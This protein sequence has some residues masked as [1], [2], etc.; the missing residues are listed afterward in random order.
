MYL[1]G[2]I[3]SG[4]EIKFDA[5]VISGMID[6]SHL[7]ILRPDLPPSLL[8]IHENQFAYPMKAGETRDFRYGITDLMN[9]L[10][11]ETVVFN[12]RFNRDVFLDECRKLFQRLP[13]ALPRWTLNEVVKKSHIIY[14]GIESK[15]AMD[16]RKSDFPDIPLIIW[17]H[18]HEHDKDPET[19][20]A[21]LENLHQRGVL[22]R[23]ALLGE[24]YSKAPSAF[25]RARLKL[26]DCI[27]VDA[28]PAR[29]EYLNW[30][31]RGD[32]V[33]SSALQENFGLSVI[34]AA[35]AGCW[36]LLPRRLAYPE[37][38]P[39]WVQAA[40]FWETQKEFEL[41]LESV[42]K[43]P[44]EQRDKLTRPLS[45]WLK[46]YDWRNQA[47]KLD[48]LLDETANQQNLRGDFLP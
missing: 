29:S 35:N 32:I 18:R 36:P 2:I 44:A 47:E 19:S 5:M 14:P 22:F 1:A 24:R 23:L 42:L 30:L 16:Y 38:M 37:V 13:D 17:N 3:P 40:C 26:A 46:K 9:I 34:E 27:V 48:S 41:M 31:N 43:M 7:K 6:L 15:A 45:R 28:F 12:S 4:R 21:V 20:F 8:Y 33:I 25:D 10:S 11:S 39:Q